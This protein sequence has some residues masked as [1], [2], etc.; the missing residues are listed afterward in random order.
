MASRAKRVEGSYP[1]APSIA[2]RTSRGT[3]RRRAMLGA[4][5]GTARNGGRPKVAPT[6]AKRR[7][8]RDAPL[9]RGT[10]VGA[11]TRRGSPRTSTPTNYELRTANC[12]LRPASRVLVSFSRKAAGEGQDFGAR[13]RTSPCLLLF[14]AVC[15]IIRSEQEIFKHR[16]RETGKIAHSGGV[17]GSAP[18]PL[19]VL[20]ET[21]GHFFLIRRRVGP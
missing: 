19:R 18:A 20:P 5:G 11:G 10:N 13:R 1:V 21:A 15:R 16:Y 8:H 9:R 7:A 3:E 17:R 4:T 12:E 2:R 6:G 14:G